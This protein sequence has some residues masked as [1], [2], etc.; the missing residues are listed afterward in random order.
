MVLAIPS[1]SRPKAMEAGYHRLKCN[2][3][4][5]TGLPVLFCFF[6][7]FDDRSRRFPRLGVTV[8][9]SH[10]HSPFLR[11]GRGRKCCLNHR[12]PHSAPPRRGVRAKLGNLLPGSPQW[13]GHLTPSYKTT[14]PCVL[15]PASLPTAPCSLSYLCTLCSLSGVKETRLSLC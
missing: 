2:E 14:V 6:S 12:E 1:C 15:P 4:T 7:V 5:I 9:V 8:T 11:V 3:T 13:A 10:K